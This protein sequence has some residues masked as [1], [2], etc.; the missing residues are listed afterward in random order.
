MISLFRLILI[1]FLFTGYKAA[2]QKVLPAF[3]IRNYDGRIVISW[4]QEYP[5]PVKTLNIQRSPDSLKHYTTIASLA[6]PQK[7][8]NNYTDYHPPYDSMY[9]RIFIAF[10]GGHYSFSNVSRPGK[11]VPPPPHE[12]EPIYIYPSKYIYTRRDNN[13]ILELPDVATHTYLVRFYDEKDKFLFELNKL[14]ESPLVI[15]KVNFVHAGWFH[16]ELYGDGKLLEKNRFNIA[17][18]NKS[19]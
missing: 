4:K 12:V 5:L 16:F 10:E 15:E 2:A 11:P 18:E 3:D 9:Y 8:E 14:Y 17:W 1:L 19:R 13:L 7:K 6:E